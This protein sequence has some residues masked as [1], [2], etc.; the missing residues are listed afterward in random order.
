MRVVLAAILLSVAI[1]GQ[2][3]IENAKLVGSC[4]GCEAVFEYGE[5]ELTPTDTL[6]DFNYEGDKL[7]ITGTI[8]LPDGKTPAENVI[9]YIYHTNQNGIYK[10][11]ENSTGWE[12]RHGYIRGWIKTGADGNYTFYSLKPGIYPN[13]SQPA[14]IHP[15]ILEP[16]GKYY[17][18]D[19]YFFAGDPV[20]ED[21]E[22]L[23]STPRG[24][25]SNILKLR[26]EGDLLVGERDFILGENVPGYD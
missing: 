11:K 19:S 23:S 16:N 2:V 24:G 22:H 17:W 21:F 1:N 13:R 12:K 10:A 7:K 14:H 6:P 9:L 8:Y 20:L 25:G 3:R 18:L 5:R 4:E 15:T 26:K